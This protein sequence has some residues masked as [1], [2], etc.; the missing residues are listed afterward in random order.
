MAKTLQFLPPLPPCGLLL[1]NPRQA[2]ST[3]D[4]FRARVP[5]HFSTP[6]PLP[7]SWAAAADLAATLASLGNDL[8]APALS[9]APVIGEVLEMLRRLPRCMLARMSGSGATCF[10]L[11][12]NAAEAIAASQ[13]VPESWW[14]SAGPL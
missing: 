10:A 8:E 14:R 6:A 2:V 5:P 9:V 13:A 3:A 4:V 12:G 11:F 7:R 1:V